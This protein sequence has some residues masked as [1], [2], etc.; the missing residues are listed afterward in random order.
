MLETESFSQISQL[1][2]DGYCMFLNLKL[3]MITWRSWK[4]K[5][6][7]GMHCHDPWDRE[8]TQLWLYISQLFVSHAWFWF[9]KIRQGGRGRRFFVLS[10]KPPLHLFYRMMPEILAKIDLSLTQEMMRHHSWASLGCTFALIVCSLIWDHMSVCSSA[11]F[12]SRKSIGN[13]L[14]SEGL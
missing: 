6:F 9:L 2:A 4:V 8:A 14:P 10:S 3:Q 7:H 1:F 5:S 11:T 12:F 13:R